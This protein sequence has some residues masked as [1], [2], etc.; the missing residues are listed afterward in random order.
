[1]ASLRILVAE[2]N[3]RAMRDRTQAQFGA[4]PGER[5]AEEIRL[6]WPGA[7]VDLVAPADG[8]RTGPSL[9]AYD[10]VAITGSAL[11]AYHDTPVVRRQVEFARS[12][13]ESGANFFGS[14]WGLQIAAM[15]AGGL[16]ERN[17]R[18]REVAFARSIWLTDA[19]EGHPM[20]A[21]RPPAFDAPAIHGDHVVRLPADAVVTAA[22]AVSEV[23]AAEI[24]HGGGTFWGTQYHPEYAI[25]DIADI[26]ARY[27]GTLVE[28]GNFD[29]LGALEVHV[30]DLRRLDADPALRSVAWRYGIA[31]EVIDR[32]RRMTEIS[33]WLARCAATQKT[34]RAT[35]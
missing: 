6:A 9:S 31:D 16:V 20:H 21:S 8:E 24:R 11:N 33:N 3:E 7:V 17:G 18:G 23:Q 2:G 30:S 4:T 35:A 13:F 28:E 32:K 27:G 5:Y 1:M 22:N 26:I 15:A 34:K 29:T 19:G 12:V 14:C 10:G 25:G